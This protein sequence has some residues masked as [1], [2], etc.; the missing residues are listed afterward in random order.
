MVRRTP[1]ASSIVDEETFARQFSAFTSGL[2]DDWEAAL[3]TNVLVAGGAV[4]AC[5]QLPPKNYER[6]KPVGG[7]AWLEFDL[8]GQRRRPCGEMPNRFQCSF[9]LLCISHSPRP[10]ITGV[11]CLIGPLDS[12]RTSEQYFRETLWPTADVDLFVYGLTRQ[13]AQRKMLSIL[14]RLRR[15]IIGRLGAENDVVFVKTVRS[16]APF[17]SHLRIE[18]CC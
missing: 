1:G 13:E 5:L 11:L 9:F 15:T 10:I 16:N 6:M 2:F 8:Y 17:G 12:A 18:W 4:L 3:W 7:A 14:T